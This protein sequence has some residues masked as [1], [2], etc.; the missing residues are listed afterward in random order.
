MTDVP[1]KLQRIALCHE[2]EHRFLLRAICREMK[3]RFNSENSHLLR[4]KAADVVLRGGFTRWND[5][6][7]Q[8]ANF[9]PE[10]GAGH[11]NEAEVYERAR[12][13]RKNP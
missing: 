5:C 7:V 11:R 10:V 8:Y 6:G 4:I 3:R 13:A 1:H 9:P 2:L 12:Q